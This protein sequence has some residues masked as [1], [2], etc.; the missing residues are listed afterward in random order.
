MKT[1]IQIPDLL[2]RAAKKK[3]LDEGVTLAQ[4]ITRALAAEISP[5]HKGAFKFNP[6]AFTFKGK[7]GIQ[8]GVDFSNW[9]Q[10]RALCYGDRE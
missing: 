10:I 1:T 9:E 3:A 4:L 2:F 8:P 6:G 7:P 5:S